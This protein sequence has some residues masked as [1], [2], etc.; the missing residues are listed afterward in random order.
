MKVANFKVSI[1][2]NAADPA[3]GDQGEHVIL[4]PLISTHLNFIGPERTRELHLALPI[5]VA[6]MPV[7]TSVSFF[8]SSLLSPD[9]TQ[10]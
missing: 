6:K 8:E 5:D 3:T 7:N 1:Q 2:P 9:T 10:C 4:Q